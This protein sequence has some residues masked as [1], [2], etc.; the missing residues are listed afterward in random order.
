MAGAGSNSW[1]KY[2]CMYN[3]SKRVDY[4]PH[5]TVAAL[6]CEQVASGSSA[7]AWGG[8]LRFWGRSHRS[9]VTLH[10]FWGALTSFKPL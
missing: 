2:A 5:D 10:G 1:P 4:C 9:A 8:I 6:P 7:G 3:C